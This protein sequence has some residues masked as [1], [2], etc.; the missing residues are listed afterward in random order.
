MNVPNYFRTSLKKSK[1]FKQ[2]SPS[3]AVTSYPLKT[4]VITIKEPS[5]FSLIDHLNKWS[6]GFEEVDPLLRFEQMNAEEDL[7][8]L[9]TEVIEGVNYTK[10]WNS[11]RAGIL[12]KYTTGEKLTIVS[13]YLPGGEK[14]LIRQVSNL[15]EKVKHRLE[16]LDDFDEGSVRK[17]MGLSQQEFVT[18]IN[19][20]NDEI[21]KAWE[22]E[23]RVKAF[24]IGIQCS[25]L[26][27]DI[28][29]M[30]FYPSKFILITDTLDTFGNLV[31]NRLKEKSFGNNNLMTIHNIDPRTV[32]ESAKETCQNW[33]YKMASIRELL[34]RLYMEMALL[35]CYVF[36]SRDEIKPA[37]K[38]LT[39]MIR[40][41]GNPLVAIYLRVY[42]CHTASKLLGKDS[43]GYFYENLKEFIEEY[44]QIFL[45][46]MRKKYETQLL[47]QDKY[48]NLFVPAL[49]W[50][51][52]GT[53]NS[54]K[55]KSDLLDEFI[56]KCEEIENNELFLCCLVSAFDSPT[57][58][59]K[60][61]KI[62][63][64]VHSYADKMVMMN[65]V[66]ASLGEHLC[67]ADTHR[68]I[69][70]ESLIQ[71][72]WKIASNMKS[73]NNFLQVLEP[74]LQ[75]ACTHLSTQHVNVILR[76]TIR[77][78]I[79]CGK[80]ADE[81]S[82]N[83]QFVIKRML[84]SIPDVEEL[85][86]M[87]VNTLAA[88]AKSTRGKWLQRACA[89]YC[90]VTVP[91]LHCTLTKTQLYL[92]SGQVALLNNCIG[93]AEA[94]FK[95]LIGL[96]PDIPDYILED[97]QKKPTHFKVAGILSDFLSTLLLLPVS[98]PL[99]SNDQLYGSDPEFISVLDRHATNICQELLVVLKMLG[100]NRETKKQYNLS[101]ELFWR[102]VRRGELNE[103]PMLSLAANLW[104]L[105]QKTQD[106]NSK[107]GA[108]IVMGFEAGGRQQMVGGESGS[109]RGASGRVGAGDPYSSSP[110]GLLVWAVC[111]G[112]VANEE[113]NGFVQPLDF[114]PLFDS[115]ATSLASEPIAAAVLKVDKN[116]YP[117]LF[118]TIVS[119]S[120]DS[121]QTRVAPIEKAFSADNFG[122]NPI[123]SQ[124]FLPPGKP[125][126]LVA[127]PRQQHNQP[128]PI[129]IGQQLSPL[130][131]DIRTV[132]DADY[133]VYKPE[134]EEQGEEILAALK[135][136]P[137]V[138]AYFKPTQTNVEVA[139]PLN[140]RKEELNENSEIEQNYKPNAYIPGPARIRRY[141][142][143]RQ[144]EN[145]KKSSDDDDDPYNY[146]VEYISKPK[147]FDSSLYS[148]AYKEQKD[149]N[150]DY[151]YPYSYDSGY[152]HKEY[153]RIKELSEKQAAEIKQNPGNCKEVKK[154][155]MTCTTCK[156]PK[157]GGNFESCSYVA[158][159]KNNKYAYSKERKFDS[160][161]EPDEAE[162][163]QQSEPA[164]KSEKY[165]QSDESSEEK[166]AKAAEPKEPNNDDNSGEKYKA[167][168]I[169]NSKPTPSEALRAA[170]DKQSS[171]EEGD[172]SSGKS[173]DYK[174]ALPGFYT[175]NEPKKDVEHVLAEFKKKDRSSCKK[176]Q[177]NGMT[178]YQ[179]IDKNG[180]KNEECMFVS[181]SA[182]KRSHLAYQ[183]LKE[184]TSKPATL[185]QGNEGAESK[186]VTTSAP[187]AQKSAAYVVDN[188]NYGK[189]LKR[190][191]AP[192]SI[193]AAATVPVASAVKPAPVAANVRK[194]KRSVDSEAERNAQIVD[195]TNIAQPEEFAG[196]DSRGAFW[197]DTMPRYSASLGVT[198]PEF[199]LS[200]SE[201][202]LM[203][204]ETVASA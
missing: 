75:F 82:G 18:K 114:G 86:L 167:Y 57:I 83:F 11:R 28:N 147:A 36:I 63:E 74:W 150:K 41:I 125:A 145:L 193:A 88:R 110:D 71:T 142:S 127:S 60:A 202:E 182:P 184:F 78:M 24:K 65:E 99:L 56:Q 87:A 22:T 166:Y 50:L 68:Q 165:V 128:Q 15:N 76:G 196:S 164:Q 51:L 146:N 34:P 66:L 45:T 102:V 159:P 126:R 38:R 135:K 30:Q 13:S 190:K 194:T 53:L 19:L 73:T 172:G 46:S 163:P 189:K 49:D 160:N 117:Q 138:A 204:D 55:C 61:P 33:M 180:L 100:D 42:L 112:V 192:Q 95:A 62:L 32:P 116:Q 98:L 183:E 103:R 153:E 170:E 173:Y 148:S 47:T 132:H 97:G 39:T 118:D 40:G 37:I 106:S 85:F 5:S 187:P 27:S 143:G 176:V 16:Q 81:F 122:F 89:A 31:F 101:L 107:L 109:G 84:K 1:R 168:Y 91:S 175:D 20:L 69:A 141:T 105:S 26:L 108:D 48:L 140:Y 79:K 181:E 77:Y 6:S 158:E 162:A 17:T 155:G 4:N 136:N 23:Q 93:Q 129:P 191:K 67:K 200:R 29:V 134:D 185:D 115:G 199:M 94:N 130:R 186:T 149:P 195:V 144:R 43:E 21:K 35:K 9:E 197:A 10:A 70:T 44:Q 96:I 14:T 123:A 8:P 203:F 119:S 25:K 7:N 120:I 3:F 133:K 177:K 104:M 201:H 137:S 113:Q 92:L 156:D 179:C 58:I 131:Y 54:N 174:K 52:F 157:T 161:D 151:E 80:P 198:L 139:H 124:S 2:D 169:H 59:K 178:C 64:M 152:D 111:E 90:F 171:E 188:T 121:L 154:D 72:W 12:N